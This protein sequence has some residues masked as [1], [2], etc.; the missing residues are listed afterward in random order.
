MA[1]WA[2]F[3]VGHNGR[4]AFDPFTVGPQL[5]MVHLSESTV[6]AN[7]KWPTELVLQ[8]NPTVESLSTNLQLR[9]NCK[10]AIYLNLQLDPTVNGPLISFYSW[11]QLLIVQWATSTVGPNCKQANELVLELDATVMH[12]ANLQS[13]CEIASEEW[14]FKPYVMLIA[15]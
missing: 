6:G 1:H 13:K 9:P 10:R 15:D 2:R 3:T 12:Y 7:C 14:I 8:L 4:I 5:Y 11:A